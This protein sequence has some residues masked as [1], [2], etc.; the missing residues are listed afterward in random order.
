VALIGSGAIFKDMD[1]IPWEESGITYIEGQVLD[2]NGNPMDNVS[3][4]VKVD[5]TVFKA[6]TNASGCY[7]IN[8][9]P[10]G[11]HGITV[12]KD[13]YKTL[14][15]NTYFMETNRER[16]V[17]RDSKNKEVIIYNGDNVYDF[18]L[19]EGTG[20]QTYGSEEPPHEFFLEK[21]HGL[22]Q[23]I[24]AVML[25][26]SILALIG[27][28]FAIQR[29]NYALAVIGGIAGIFS[30]GFFIGSVLAFIALFILLLSSKEFNGEAAE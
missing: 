18:T 30:F 19:V 28:Y 23:A 20:I 24:G 13:G 17:H 11:Y 2:A 4:S 16:E 12:E 14:V 15:Y 26:C 8:G 1:E 27:G 7:R 22:F 3:V 25:V 6:M 9:I 29:T 10:T 21:F 5:D